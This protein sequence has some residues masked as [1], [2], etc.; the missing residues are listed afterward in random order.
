MGF[1]PHI[2]FLPTPVDK[3]VLENEYIQ[4]KMKQYT[5]IFILTTNRAYFLKKHLNSYRSYLFR[6]HSLN[7]AYPHIFMLFLKQVPSHHHKQLVQEIAAEPNP[8]AY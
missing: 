6:N 1:S 8:N 7:F 5:V 2:T 3:K 4:G